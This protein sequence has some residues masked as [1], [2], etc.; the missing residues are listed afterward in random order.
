MLWSSVMQE[1]NVSIIVVPKVLRDKLGEDGANAL[2]ELLN[3][4]A[5]HARG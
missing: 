1:A 5:Q 4:S 2:V 3:G